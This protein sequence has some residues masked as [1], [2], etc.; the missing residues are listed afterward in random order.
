MYYLEKL[1]C[2]AH[3]LN[4]THHILILTALKMSSFDAGF[5]LYLLSLLPFSSLQKD[6]FKHRIMW[7]FKQFNVSFKSYKSDKVL[8]DIT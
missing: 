7:Y 5:N 4:I 3:I 2:T 1:K 8:K 6:P